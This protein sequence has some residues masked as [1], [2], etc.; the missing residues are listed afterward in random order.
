MQTVRFNSTMVRLKVGDINQMAV[1]MFEFQFHNG[2][3]KREAESLIRK[4]YHLFQFH[5]GSIKRQGDAPDYVTTDRVSI[6]QWF[7]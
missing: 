4:Q 6:P 2:S 7:D 3:I 1:K 5:N